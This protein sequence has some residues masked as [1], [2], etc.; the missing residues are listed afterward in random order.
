[1]Q[2]LLPM[3]ATGAQAAA[4][5]PSPNLAAMVPPIGS[6]LALA[7]AAP[8][9]PTIAT[10]LPVPNGRPALALSWSTA[11]AE[12]GVPVELTIGT[13]DAAGRLQ[14][15]LGDTV[16]VHVS[17]DRAK[18]A[19][20]TPLAGSPGQRVAVAPSGGTAHLT[21]TFTQP[22][23][24]QVEA[25]LQHSPETVGVN[26]RLRVHAVHFV[27]TGPGTVDQYRPA[28][29]TITAQDEQGNP[30]A[31]YQGDLLVATSDGRALLQDATTQVR[32]ARNLGGHRF[33]PNDHGQAVVRVTFAQSGAQTLRLH[34]P[35]ATAVLATM[36]VQV[37]A[38][39]TTLGAA[40]TP[41]VLPTA[42][43]SPA[44]STTA[45]SSSTVPG[46][47]LPN[48]TPT[49]R[50]PATPAPRAT[51]TPT[52]T[53]T[54][55]AAGATRAATAQPRATRQTASTAPY[56]VGG[57]RF[58]SPLLPAAGSAVHAQAPPLTGASIAR[59][60]PTLLALGSPGFA[61][62]FSVSSGI[63]AGV[64][65]SMTVQALDVAGL[66]DPTYQGPLQLHSSDPTVGL[67]Y[68]SFCSDGVSYYYQNCYTFTQADLGQHTFAV[69]F[70]T[71]NPSGQTITAVDPHNTAMTGT[72]PALPVAET[73]L[74][75]TTSA[76]TVAQDAP[77]TF[78]VQAQ[79]ANQQP[80]TGYQGTV[81]VS[82]SY[83]SV[84]S[85]GSGVSWS[86]THTFGPNDAGR[87]VFTV[88]F[89]SSGTET[90]SFTDQANGSRVETTPPITVTD[91]AWGSY[92]HRSHPT[93]A[94][95]PDGSTVWA[96]LGAWGRIYTRRNVGSASVPVWGPLVTVRDDLGSGIGAESPSLVAFGN[97]LALFHAFSDGTYAQVWVT[98]SNDLGN[99]WSAPVQLSL[100][101][102][103]VAR[104]QAVVSGGTVFLFWSRANTDG[105][106]AEMTSTDL[107]SWTAKA[108]VGHT[109]GPVVSNTNS[110]FGIA[111]LTSGS[112]LLGWVGLSNSR[113]YNGEVYQNPD[114][115]SAQ[116]ATSADLT[117]WSATTE[118]T[119]PYENR[120]P[121]DVAVGQDPG[122]GQLLA[123]TEQEVNW[124]NYVMER[125][126]ADGVT[127]SAPATVAY[128]HALPDDGWQ[129]FF[130]YM[131]TLIA[132]TTL[133]A[134]GM[135]AC[136]GHLSPCYGQFGGNDPSSV[137]GVGVV[138]LDALQEPQFIPT[139]SDQPQT[140]DCPTGLCSQVH[141]PVDTTTG[142]ELT[143]A[144]DLTIAARGMPLSVSRS[145]RSLDG[146]A[147]Q[148]SAFGKGW[149]WLYGM[150]AVTLQGGSVAIVEAT[151]R[152][153]IFW[154][155][156]S[157]WTPAAYVNATLTAGSGGGYV[158]TRHDQS[159]WTFDG[160]G[161]LLSITDRNG[162]SQTLSYAGG[163]LS[164]ITGAGGR[165]LAVTMD[166]NGHITQIS[167]PGSLSAAYTYDSNGNLATA[168]DPSGAVTHYSYDGQHQLLTITDGNGHTV[169]SN[170]Y[171]GG[172]RVLAQADALGAVTSFGY[173]LPSTAGGGGYTTVTD[174]RG[175]ETDY[176]YD[177]SLRM[178]ERDAHQ[179]NINGP[180]LQRVQWTYD[181]D[182]N[183]TSMT[184]ANGVATTYTYDG[185]ANVLTR[186]IDPTGLNLRWSF[187]YDS[188]NDVLTAG[189]PN[190]HTTTYGYD[191]HGNRTAV[192][193]ALNQT[194]A[195]AYDGTGQ[196]TS[197]TDA[198]GH[199]TTFG[200][201]GS[202]DLATITTAD[203]A[204]T[205]MAY[206]AAGRLTGVT[207]PL[208]HT[209]T[210][211]YD[212]DS[213][214]TAQT[215][216]LNQTTTFAYDAVGNRTKVTDALNRA[217]SYGYDAKNRLLTVTDA[218]GQVT[219]NAYD[220]NDNL[221]S[222]TDPNGHATTA[223]YD[224]LNRRVS[225]VDAL[226]NQT[227]Y[228]YDAAGNQTS[229]TDALSHTT[230]DTF[231]HANR[232][233][234]VTD[235]LGG[236][237]S[238]GYDGAGNRSGV[239]DANS[240]S[241]TFGYD[242]AN[243]LLTAADALSNTTHYSYDAVGNLL[244][245]T[246]PGGAV[247]RQ[248][249][250]AAGRRTSMTDATGMTTYGY[251]NANRLT[252][253]TAPSTPPLTTTVSLAYD[254]AGERTSLTYPSGHQ[255]S[256]AY[257]ARGQLQS[258]TDWLSNQTSYSYDNAGRL[259]SIASP[260]G[261]AGS[262]GYDN[263]DRLTSVAY[264]QG[265][266]SLESIGYTRN[267]VGDPTAMTDSTGSTSYGYDALDRL[268]SAAYPNADAM[269]YA[270]D[271][272]GNR[273]GLTVN[274]VLT[275][276]A[277]DAADRLTQAGSTTYTYDTTGNQ[278]TKTAAGVT[279]TYAYDL[280]N[281]LT[282]ISG[283][284]TAS[285]AY[286]GDGLRVGKTV[287]S[288][289]TSYVW[290]P[291][292]L[293]HVVADSTGDEYLWGQ[294]LVGQVTG[295]VASYAHSDGL[296]SIRLVTGAAG[297]VLGRQ[298]FDAYGASRSQSGTQLPFGFTGEQ[299]DAES[300]LV[301]LRARYLDPSTGRF[302][303]ADSFGGM[304]SNPQSLNRYGYAEGNPIENTDPSGHCLEDLCIGEAFA[305]AAM[306]S[307]V[308]PGAVQFL[309][310]FGPEVYDTIAA[311]VS[312]LAASNGND[313]AAPG[314]CPYATAT[315]GPATS[316][317]P[318]PTPEDTRYLVYQ[319]VSPE[320]VPQYVGITRQ[321][322]GHRQRQ[323]R[324]SYLNK[325][326]DFVIQPVAGLGGLSEEDARS[327]EEALM[328][329]YQSQNVVLMNRNHSIGPNRPDYAE[330]VQR[331]F[332]L[333]RAAG[334]VQ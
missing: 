294:G 182:N 184:D 20:G 219:T 162:N 78:T 245:T 79:D 267:A 205:T 156:G 287:N 282:G 140:K 223:T 296:G 122:S 76:T 98:T 158:L 28:D 291:T 125:T 188:A 216:A 314:A 48:A 258:V 186:T 105:T 185:N 174:A 152:Q 24:P 80:V 279:T 183:V 221:L 130:A 66:P 33:G 297:V 133:M 164:A 74:S 141:G 244:Q 181:A 234:S 191:G 200:Y 70:N 104:V 242:D 47:A 17:D 310:D 143:S 190:S 3:S 262:L 259:T 19:G 57:A 284:T 27:L 222:V 119:L 283:P 167:G 40:I 113:E 23:T 274:G 268:T 199:A 1:M 101:P 39:P 318:A 195:S 10:P 56:G 313:A 217:V 171:G 179:G 227:S 277:F 109:V 34:R 31:G 180:L 278:L 213:R 292:G 26:D 100:E 272:V 6:A 96:Y 58:F 83:S 89:R 129:G 172:G 30:V 320:G 322:P 210:L 121:N 2:F 302:L 326:P 256:Y 215:N 149:S 82:S 232:L 228:G 231:D 73:Y 246:L 306:V 18:I 330:R 61:V 163:R 252:S 261:V 214:V 304:A 197:V 103:N 38:A 46:A 224:P 88:T 145:Y 142:G 248:G 4:P 319:S 65:F 144:T 110:N 295:P 95:L 32:L 139:G 37:M 134:A 254:A 11:D 239:T 237:A 226:G 198:N 316:V 331:G 155:S 16:Q 108:I 93:G 111:R 43:S 84:G 166:G 238:Y 161:N 157:A 124:D 247:N 81:G 29:F 154:K 211:A 255:L 315:P 275:T 193:N 260:N 114:Y 14:P 281:R 178:T 63:N 118:I 263:A 75:V 67:P 324:T 97:T 240:H 327:A 271:A 169:E 21:I 325:G 265:T 68:F 12:V 9:L 175:N 333:L 233:V 328:V 204:V 241:Q 41:T 251:D 86:N 312:S 126:S 112:W 266:T 293:G 5:L 298:S 87:A 120:Y 269:N 131:P 148:D 116:V 235:A 54:A 300:G 288:V 270:Y 334:I 99:T 290:D 285:Y 280:L 230:T 305:V 53:T 35:G 62:T 192:T 137:E 301:Y 15:T 153:A 189:D 92:I 50:P 159:V 136:Y 236:K 203:N 123:L 60:G 209:T 146:A 168:T 317:A 299:T 49:A 177:A 332:D 128:D 196:L 22:G 127:W 7:P 173:A 132:G 147:G 106:L 307:I 249:Y 117:T 229:V 201:S 202:G 160:S 85:W 36:A 42:T 253:L 323:H 150:H 165:S 176:F 208:G 90:A 321:S 329:Y 220:Q 52:A 207:D 44:A 115:P 218:L 77:V 273:T 107:S 243:R 303:T 13:A 225:A 257:T 170:T 276:S 25:W 309:Q 138:D 51:A 289:A 264:L 72:S 135:S 151:G 286:N 308:A 311:G 45:S 64:P 187:S 250:D 59:L 69:S 71:A 55:R 94:K 194:T 91:P 212:G 102:G 8:A 206:D